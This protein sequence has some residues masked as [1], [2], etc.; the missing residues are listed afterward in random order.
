MI[1]ASVP[2]YTYMTGSIDL[3][4]VQV[5]WFFKIFYLVSLMN[6]VAMIWGVITLRKVFT[7]PLCIH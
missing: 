5:E 4:Q 3:L 6:D 1:H 2:V 7:V